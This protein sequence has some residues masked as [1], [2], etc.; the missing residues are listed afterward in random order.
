MRESK[1]VS[2]GGAVFF[3]SLVSALIERDETKSKMKG[4]MGLKREGAGNKRF[5]AQR[6]KIL[7][8]LCL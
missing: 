7:L 5:L 6:E 4:E 1:G 3:Q 8:P 2:Q